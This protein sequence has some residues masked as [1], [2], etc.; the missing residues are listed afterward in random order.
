MKTFRFCPWVFYFKDCITTQNFVQKI[1]FYHF[2][3]LAP[4]NSTQ[5][6]LPKIGETSDIKK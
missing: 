3:W 5:R 4:E 2:W 6:F 1:K